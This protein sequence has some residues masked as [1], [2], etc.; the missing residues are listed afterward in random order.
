MRTSFVRTHHARI[1][2]VAAGPWRCRP[3]QRV[4]KRTCGSAGQLLASH[5][6]LVGAF[7]RGPWESATGGTENLLKP[8]WVKTDND[9]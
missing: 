2:T 5:A 7:L 8:G 4:H 3:L 1:L 6:Y 9:D